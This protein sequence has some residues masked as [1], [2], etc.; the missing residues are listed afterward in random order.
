MWDFVR[1][2]KGRRVLGEEEE[3][4]WRSLLAAGMAARVPGTGR[5]VMEG[6][7]YMA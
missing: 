3:V 6:V 4:S 1:G 7:E 2:G 5:A